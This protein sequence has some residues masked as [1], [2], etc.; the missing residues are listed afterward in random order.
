MTDST[1]IWTVAIVNGTTLLTLVVREAINMARARVRR[2]DELEDRQQVA[3][4]L[5]EHDQWE[6]DERHKAEAH[7]LAVTES[8]QVN[9]ELTQKAVTAAHS[10]YEVANNVN[11]KLVAIGDVRTMKGQEQQRR[12]EDRA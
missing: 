12:K 1:A 3:R 2:R 7:Q 8:L 10:A 4:K 6:R 11:D 5:D 9:T